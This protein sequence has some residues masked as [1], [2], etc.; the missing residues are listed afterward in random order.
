[1]KK[2]ESSEQ[3]GRSPEMAFGCMNRTGQGNGQF[4]TWLRRFGVRRGHAKGEVVMKGA[5]VPPFGFTDGGIGDSGS[6]SIGPPDLV[7]PRGP[8]ARLRDPG[9]H[10][11][12]I[13]QKG[14]DLLSPM[15]GSPDR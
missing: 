6:R 1:M 2:D 12:S 5:A 9:L 14:R 11:S 10:A 8:G 15:S 7:K 13:E 3:L 4:R